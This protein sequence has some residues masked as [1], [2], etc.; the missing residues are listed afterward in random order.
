VSQR[1][2]HRVSILWLVGGAFIGLL[3][4]TSICALAPSPDM[5]SIAF[6]PRLVARWADMEPTFRNFPAF[7]FL[8]FTATLFWFLWKR[9]V[10]AAGAFYSMLWVSVFSI[11]LE[12]IQLR[13][14]GRFFDTAD[15]A[16]SI[17]GVVAGTAVAYFLS[18]GMAALFFH[19]D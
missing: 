17:T 2:I 4:L 11:T 10:C 6:L 7:A 15:I 19:R 9:V 12:L 14:P 18:L 1:S 16:W 5:K 8:A 3:L 13:L